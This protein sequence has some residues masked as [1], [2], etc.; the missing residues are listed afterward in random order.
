MRIDWK[1]Q[2]ESSVATSKFF[3]LLCAALFVGSFW[4]EDDRLF[5]QALA[6]S[7]ICAVIFAAKYTSSNVA[8]AKS[9]A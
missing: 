5:Y 6:A 2:S 8:W 1:Q 7:V 9:D 4:I 3:A